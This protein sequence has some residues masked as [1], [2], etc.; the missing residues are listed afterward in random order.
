MF[1]SL[2]FLFQISYFLEFKHPT[3]AEFEN[4]LKI[5]NIQHT[6]SVEI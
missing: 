5:I 6:N 3:K 4:E 2:I 1:Y